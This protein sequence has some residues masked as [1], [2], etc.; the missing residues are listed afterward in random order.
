MFP[1]DPVVVQQILGRII[2]RSRGE[3]SLQA[4]GTPVEDQASMVLTGGGSLTG[5]DG[6]GGG[7]GSR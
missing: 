6:V 7:G 3:S 4:L 5:G 1:R 2:S